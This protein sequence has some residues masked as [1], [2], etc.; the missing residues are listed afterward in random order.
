[1]TDFQKFALAFCVVV[2]VVLAVGF[3]WKIAEKRG[4]RKGYDAALAIPVKRDTITVRETL[5]VIE[6]KEKYVYKDKLVFVP[7]ETRDTISVHDTTYIALQSEKKIYEDDDYRA[8]VSGI[9]P[10]LEEI[11]VFPKTITITETRNIK[12]HWG[13]SVTAGAGV[14]YNGSLHPGA[15]IVAGFG[16]TF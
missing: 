8:V 10:K 6:P 9:Y 1:M 2:G 11:S 15:G 12:K 3:S 16:Y 13:F 7:I 4:Y 14:V 5:T